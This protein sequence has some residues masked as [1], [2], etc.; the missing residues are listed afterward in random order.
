[1]NEYTVCICAACG[2]ESRQPAGQRP[3]PDDLEACLNAGLREARKGIE[4]FLH[5]CPHC[6]YT[7]PDISLGYGLETEQLTGLVLSP[8]YQ[9]IFSFKAPLLALAYMAWAQVCLIRQDSR[10]ASLSIRCSSAVFQGT[11][12]DTK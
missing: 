3:E 7:A 6:L 12:W 2:L 10:G 9:N 11:A 1:M 8:E 5:C 4:G